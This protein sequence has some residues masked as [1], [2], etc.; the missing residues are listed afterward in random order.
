[1]FDELKMAAGV[2]SDSVTDDCPKPIGL[3][4]SAIEDPGSMSGDLESSFEE[5]HGFAG[6]WG[7]DRAVFTMNN[8]ATFATFNSI[9]DNPTIGDERSFLRI[10]RITSERTDM[11]QSADLIPGN[12]YLVSIYCHNG[13]SATFNEASYDYSGLAKGVRVSSFFPRSVCS[14]QPSNI[15]AIITSDNARPSS[16]WAYVAL[17]TNEPIV[18]LMFE[19]DSARIYNDGRASGS[20]L[21]KGLFSEEGV[22]IGFDSLDGIIPG[23]EEYHCI[24]TYVIRVE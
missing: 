7:P 21:S 13:A 23:C 18:N 19:E 20:H 11:L 3:A 5:P 22:L 6:G 12:K 2:I 14:D 16:V 9:M 10:G 15:S 24:V 8:P 17:T 1:M 4:P